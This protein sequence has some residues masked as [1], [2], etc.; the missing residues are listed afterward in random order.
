[1]TDLEIEQTIKTI[2]SDHF[3]V[4]DGQLTADT[5][6][7]NDLGADSLDA[8]DLLMQLEDKFDITTP[9][10]DTDN[11]RTVGDMTAYFTEFL[12]AK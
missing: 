3:H 8:V 10:E 2:V 6:F 11:L 4:E 12:K 7:V 9:D 5:H 1:M